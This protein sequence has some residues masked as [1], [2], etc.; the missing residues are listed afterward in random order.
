VFRAVWRL[1]ERLLS[2]LFSKPARIRRSGRLQYKETGYEHPFS[3]L[4]FKMAERRV[5]IAALF[6]GKAG[7]T[8]PPSRSASSTGSSKRVTGVRPA[9]RAL[10]SSGASKK[11]AKPSAPEQLSRLWSEEHAPASSAELSTTIHSGTLNRVREWLEAATA[12]RDLSRNASSQ[13]SSRSTSE[14]EPAGGQRPLPS[15]P[16]R[17]LIL[18]GQPGTGKSAC[19]RVLAQE[20]QLRLSEHHDTFGQFKTWQGS[21][22]ENERML[23]DPS[24][25]DAFEASLDRDFRSPYLSQ[26]DLFR[27]FLRSGSYEPLQLGFLQ[28]AR[29]KEKST[30]A[31]SSNYSSTLSSRN[32]S[33]SGGRHTVLL[34]ESLPS[35]SPHASSFGGS[36]RSLSE[37]PLEQLR[38]SLV[39][40]LSN[41]LAAPAVLVFSDVAEKSDSVAALER[42]F[43]SAITASPLVDIIQFNA[44]TEC[45]RLYSLMLPFPRFL[46]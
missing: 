20:L 19:V 31:P 14:S 21:D 18:C 29:L 37:S 12:P 17:L 11:K 4:R 6:S 45:K 15:P 13:Q 39:D 27:K 2:N 43:S 7:S 30:G 24:R 16:K 34:I 8:P 5:G 10:A 28:P 9:K 1:W 40:F 44:I 46:L 26:I 23:P 42:L 38:A 25:D 41:A 32:S 22:G 36:D 33:S 3:V 35:T